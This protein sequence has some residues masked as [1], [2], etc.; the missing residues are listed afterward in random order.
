[1]APSRGI[2]RTADGIVVKESRIERHV[3]ENELRRATT[4]EVHFGDDESNDP[5]GRTPYAPKSTALKERSTRLRIARQQLPIWG[6]QDEIKGKLRTHD[7]L[8]LVGETGSGKST[9]VPQFLVHESWCKR[10]KL[11]D[12]SS[13]GG[14]IAITEPRRVAATSLARRVAEEMGSPLGTASPASQVGYSV[15]F[16]NSTGPSTRIKFLTEGMLL[17]EMLRDPWLREYSAVVVDEVHERGLNVDLVLGFLRR[18][19]EQSRADDGRGGN[20]IKMIVMSATADMEKIQ[21]YFLRTKQPPKPNGQSNGHAADEEEEWNGFSDD[22][23]GAKDGPS[24]IE[25]DTPAPSVASLTIKGRQ[26]PVTIH[27]APS[28]LPDITEACLK[29]IIDIHVHAPLPGDILVFLTGQETVESLMSLVNAYSASIRAD[30]KL[31]S[32]LPALVVLPL[33]AALP[34]HLQQQVFQP[35]PKFT[36]KI[37]ISTNIAETSITVPGI[38]HVIDSGKHKRRIFRPSLNLDSLLTVPISR[39]SADQRSGRAGRDAPGHAYRLYTEAGFYTLAADTEPEILRCDLSQLVLTLKS[40]GVENLGTFPLLTM[41]PRRALERA[42]MHLLQL[43]ALSPTTGAVS[44]L[45][46]EM[47]LLPLPSHLARILLSSSLLKYACVDE[48]ID[49]VS[50]LSVE[51]VFLNIHNSLDSH[52][53][54]GSDSD[55]PSNP[56][57]ELR[58]RLHRREGDHLTLLA[59]VQAY[60]AE[61]TDRKRWCEDRGISH[62]AMQSVMDARKQLASIMKRRAHGEKQYK[63]SN[64]ATKQNGDATHS[65]NTEPTAHTTKPSGVDSDL[66]TR[67]LKCLLTGLHPN[68]ARL[69]STST[70]LSTPRTQNTT[71]SSPS[72]YLTLSTNQPVSIHPSSVL[73]THHSTA[74]RSGTSA[75][76]RPKA[77]AIMSSEYVYT[78]KPYARCVSAVQLDWVRDVFKEI[79][80]EGIGE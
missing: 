62:R 28:P 16:D 76:A 25:V 65:N 1:M 8:L 22:D 80:A 21:D 37:I 54:N 50:A 55:S 15:R 41:P 45:G 77:E 4:K 13:V 5:S 56:R 72:H 78:T 61:N 48:I 53:P 14:C 52:Q 73:F 2:K 32:S 34:P 18:M 43:S 10:K 71:A 20:R 33:Y 17:Q 47:S 29:R 6:H 27:Y 23:D 64:S 39:S 60:V 12:G 40:H 11:V 9:Q 36:R 74:P 79:G 49:I 3:H 66:T 69:A 51:N 75:S 30:P 35:T 38:R 59:V 26:H 68:V 70:T 42:I 63:R 7:T 31:S 24:Q 57:L 44:P 19:Q 67:I 46:R 58:S